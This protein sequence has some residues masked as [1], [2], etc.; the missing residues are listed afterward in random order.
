MW[1]S[2]PRVRSPDKRTGK[3]YT[4]WQFK[5]GA[6]SY[7]TQL[8]A[9]FYPNGVKV[10]PACIGQYLTVKDFAFWLMDDANY[11]GFAM[12]I[13]THGYSKAER[14]LSIS[15]INTNF[16]LSSYI[17]PVDRNR[18]LKHIIFIPATDKARVRSSV[19]SYFIPSMLFK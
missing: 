3:I 12:E 6:N 8:H 1:S 11:T 7:F 9:I 19:K 16:G 5:C 17:R 15:V 18:G 14:E 10:I 13:N 4:G 2:D